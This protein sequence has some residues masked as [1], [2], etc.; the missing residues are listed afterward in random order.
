MPP[1]ASPAAS[2]S[3]HLMVEPPM[4]SPAKWVFMMMEWCGEPMYAARLSVYE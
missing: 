1:Q 4:S 3:M 2:T